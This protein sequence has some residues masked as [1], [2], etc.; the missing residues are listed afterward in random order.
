MALTYWKT[1]FEKYG[2]HVTRKSARTRSV[3]TWKVF[4]SYRKMDLALVQGISVVRTSNPE[5]S[6]TMSTLASF[7]VWTWDQTA[8]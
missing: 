8:S 2:V 1:T 5:L 7:S 6:K 3:K 4:S